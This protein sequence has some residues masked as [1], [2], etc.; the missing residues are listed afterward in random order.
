[1]IAIE[2][3]VFRFVARVISYEEDGCLT[4]KLGDSVVFLDVENVPNSIQGWVEGKGKAIR[5]YPTNL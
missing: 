2:N 1:M 3:N 4:V 5:L